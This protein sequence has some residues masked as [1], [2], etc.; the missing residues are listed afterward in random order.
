[1]LWMCIRIASL[2][3]FKSLAVS[4]NLDYDKILGA[5][6]MLGN[7]CDDTLKLDGSGEEMDE[8]DEMV[9]I[10]SLTEIY[11]KI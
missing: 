3:C 4:F 1:M 6:D 10:I 11:H 5:D 7:H 8:E 9:R 2:R